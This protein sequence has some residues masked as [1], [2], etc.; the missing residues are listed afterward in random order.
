A[1][2]AE[3]LSNKAIF[4]DGYPEQAPIESMTLSFEKLGLSK[5]KLDGV[6]NSTRVDFTNRLDQLGKK[7]TLDFSYTTSPSL[8]G[9]VSHL[10]IFL[11]ENLVTVLP[12][13]DKT[14]PIGTVSERSI[15]LNPKLIKDF[16]QIRFELV[17]FYDLVCQDDYSK[18]I[19]AE[20]SKSSRISIERQSL[21]LESLL[22]YF[23]APFF[24]SRDYNKV[25]L[26]FVFASQPDEN[27]LE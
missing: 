3:P 2:S 15:V 9:R 23:P 24:D 1:I 14:T 12:I 13:D 19:W 6:S 26:P 16:N 7:L 18:T 11:N 22:E 4:D 5:F 20:L 21:A 27:T 25:N 10:K 8:I 17:G